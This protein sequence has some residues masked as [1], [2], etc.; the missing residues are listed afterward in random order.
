MA[1]GRGFSVMPRL[2]LKVLNPNRSNG[3]PR[4]GALIDP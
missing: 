4:A 3:D 1:L 2:T